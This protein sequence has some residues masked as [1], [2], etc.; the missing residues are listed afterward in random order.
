M[1]N[2]LDYF[3]L[4]PILLELSSKDQNDTIQIAASTLQR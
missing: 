2:I 3:L 1:G 4:Y